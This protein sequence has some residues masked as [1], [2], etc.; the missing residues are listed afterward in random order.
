M[1]VDIDAQAY[2]IGQVQAHVIGIVIDVDVVAIPVP[3]I[4]VTN[5]IWGNAKEIPAESKSFGAA[6][7]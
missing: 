5:V 6:A 7:A 3:S 4:A 2:V 1:N